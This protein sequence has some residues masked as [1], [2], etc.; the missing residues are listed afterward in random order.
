[1]LIDKLLAVGHE[2]HFYL[3]DLSKN[4]SVLRL[5]MNGY[6]GH[7]HFDN[8]HFFVA[9]ANGLYCISQNCEIAWQNLNL[10]IDDVIIT[11]FTDKKIIG[12]G[13]WDP[14]VGWRDFLLE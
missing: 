11:D 14:P 3:F 8:E 2:G 4:L 5:K 12:S 9:G 10:A 6:F 1:M 13:E 7:I